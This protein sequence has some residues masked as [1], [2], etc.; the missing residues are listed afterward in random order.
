MVLY[1]GDVSVD[2]DA[3]F[4]VMAGPLMGYG[5]DFEGTLEGEPAKEIYERAVERTR[6]LVGNPLFETFLEAGVVDN[7]YGWYLTRI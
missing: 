1:R 7:R 4:R 6:E 2:E 5:Y 3:K